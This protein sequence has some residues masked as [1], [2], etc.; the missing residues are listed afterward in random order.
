M[1]EKN[2]IP[3]RD[4]ITQRMVVGVIVVLIGIGSVVVYSVLSQQQDSGDEQTNRG[5][6][7]TLRPNEDGYAPAMYRLDV[8]EN[9][10]DILVDD[11]RINMTGEVSKDGKS[12]VYVSQESGNQLPQ[13]YTANLDGSS[14]QKVTTSGTLYKREPRWHN[15]SIVFSAMDKEGGISS[16]PDDW[17][18]YI[19]DLSGNERFITTGSHPMWSPDG[20]KII[21]VRQD[22]IYAY[23]I[24]TNAEF[25][26]VE[27]G[28]GGFDMGTSIDV[29]DDGEYLAWSDPYNETVSIVSVS[30]WN[31]VVVEP[32]R[33][34]QTSGFWVVFSPRT[35]FLLVEEFDNENG[36]ITNP[37]LSVYNIDTLEQNKVFDLGEEDL[38]SV[39]VTDWK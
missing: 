8:I 25:R 28:E 39:Y 10:I 5:V 32:F 29:S 33:T 26:I 36:E 17:G 14:V 12:I 23:N 38:S 31:P 16:N 37:M 22:G 30:S 18:V 3:T 35:Q 4:T 19:T 11:G 15:S 2:T 1:N 34:I 24:N 7:L 13:V 6:Y 9:T 21:T 27:A 20:D